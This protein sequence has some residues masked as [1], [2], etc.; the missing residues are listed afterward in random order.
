MEKVKVVNRSKNNRVLLYQAEV[1]DT[2]FTRLIGLMGRPSLPEGRG[3][4]I[5]PCRSIHT[6][7]MRFSLDIVFLDWE[8]RVCRHSFCVPPGRVVKGGKR[9]YCVIEARAGSFSKDMV[10]IGDCVWILP[11]TAG[12]EE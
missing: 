12:G 1:A 8:N 4:L 9:A 11:I 2:Y 3:M 5:I 6:L 10:E 7:G